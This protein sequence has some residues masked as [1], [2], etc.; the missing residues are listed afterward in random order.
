MS[1]KTIGILGSSPDNRNLGVG[2]L[3]RGIINAIVSASKEEELNIIFFV[4]WEIVYERTEKVDGKIVNIKISN[5]GLKITKRLSRNL[6]VDC[7]LAFVVSIMP[8][9]IVKKNILKVRPLLSDMDSCGLICDIYGGDSFTDLYGALIFGKS[10]LLRELV[11]LLKKKYVLLPQ[12]YGP[13]KKKWVQ[14]AAKKLLTYALHRYSRDQKNTINVELLWKNKSEVPLIKYSPDMA[15]M[16]SVKDV[17]DKKFN[18]WFLKSKSGENVVGVNASGL[19]YHD[20]TNGINRFNLN[21]PYENVMKEVI[22]FLISKNLRILL[23]PHVY[24]YPVNWDSPSHENDVVP[25]HLL[26]NELQESERDS[27]Y[28]IDKNYDPE[29]IRFFI[30][31]CNFFI[32][33]RMHSC[34]AALSLFVP[35]MALAYSDKYEGL[36]SS[37]NISEAVCDLRYSS[38]VRINEI[39][40][41]WMQEKEKVREK[42]NLSIPR[43]KENILANYINILES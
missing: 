1:V 35:A 4:P 42:I 8:L 13:Y 2:A 41:A 7:F 16:A 15:F 43:V 19:L 12:T 27:I 9:Y 10:F 37:L 32:G 21:L 34:I 38:I 28:L 18:E 11:M 14:G 6:I 30:N 5:Y 39:L 24:N 3:A 20:S 23:I 29:E 40:E 22:K 33:T 25:L 31:K 17:D 26:K 36:Y